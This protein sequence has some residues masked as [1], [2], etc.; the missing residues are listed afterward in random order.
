[1]AAG[2]DQYF[3]ASNKFYSNRSVT[4]PT[5][6]DIMENEL[7]GSK[8]SNAQYHYN[9]L[10]PILVMSYILYKLGDDDFQ[11]LLDDVFQKKAG[12]EGD[13]FFLKNELAKKD[14]ISVWNQFYATRY[15]YLRIA[16]A[17]LD[18]WENDTCAGKYLKTIHE[19]RI[20]KNRQY[21]NDDRVGLPL[22][23]A[24]F[25]HANYK[26]MVNR[27]VMGMDGYGGQTILIDFERGRIIATQAIHD[28]M[29]F[30]KSGSFDFKKIVYER[31]KNGKPASGLKQPQEPVIDPQQVILKRNAAIETEKKAKKYWDDYYANNG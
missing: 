9:N 28:N 29:K 10:N 21:F 20:P 8:K 14:D 5:V 23:Y 12:I 15:D 26:E 2:T 16:K 3:M 27:P 11:Q 17:M 30:P 22:G 7:K 24:G 1:M 18:D 19:R 13:V 6:Q 4:W 25:F 31:I